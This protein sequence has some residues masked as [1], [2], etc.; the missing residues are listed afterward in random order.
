MIASTFGKPAGSESDRMKTL[1][2]ESSA[3]GGQAG[4]EPKRRA[5]GSL[6]RT[7]EVRVERDTRHYR[8]VVDT[9]RI[10]ELA[11]RGASASSLAAVFKM[12]VEDIEATLSGLS[13][14]T[15]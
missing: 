8:T 13:P 9:V 2:P 10:G 5:S 3:G 15:E 6:R 14:P 12:S 4:S 1:R 7:G 11:R